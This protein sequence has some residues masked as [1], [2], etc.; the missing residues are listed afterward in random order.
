MDGNILVKAYPNVVTGLVK[1]SVTA[2]DFNKPAAITIYNV[3]G[4]IVYKA[5]M[6]RN[7]VTTEKD[8]D[9]TG[10]INGVYF[11]EVTIGTRAREVIKVV[12]L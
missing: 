5:Q 8:I 10:F 7:Q 6:L 9:M 1:L 2:A 3:S 11:I 4:N 12:R